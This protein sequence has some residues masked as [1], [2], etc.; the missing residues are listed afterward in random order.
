MKLLKAFPVK[1]MSP[2]KATAI[3]NLM[4]KM[5][6]FFQEIE[7]IEKEGSGENMI[8]MLESVKEIFAEKIK[9]FKSLNLDDKLLLLAQNS[10]K[11]GL[12]CM[13]IL[14]KSLKREITPEIRDLLEKSGLLC[15]VVK[16]YIIA[17]Q[18]GSLQK[19][20]FSFCNKKRHH[21]N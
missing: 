18:K 20:P 9:D 14:K 21:L 17:P 6:E 11:S 10:F 15:L 16:L 13:N 1:P 2:T 12:I 7:K 19:L 4:S 5:E 8:S 3:K